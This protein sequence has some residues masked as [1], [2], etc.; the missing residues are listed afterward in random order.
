MKSAWL[1]G[2]K[3]EEAKTSRRGIL[4][5]NRDSL[6]IL[7]EILLKKVKESKE[8][9]YE[10][11]SWAYYQADSNGYNRALTEVLDLINLDKD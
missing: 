11:A 5:S 2:C 10:K 7:K 9:D 4:L 3:G 1:H 6:D 8:V